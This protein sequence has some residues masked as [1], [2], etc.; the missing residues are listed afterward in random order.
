MM[1]DMTYIKSVRVYVRTHDNRASANLQKILELYDQG[2]MEHGDALL[3][4][5]TVLSDERGI[6]D[7]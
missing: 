7:N 2:E 3:R 1:T 4:I 6:H 5:H